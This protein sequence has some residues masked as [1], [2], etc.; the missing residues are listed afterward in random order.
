MLFSDP[1][2]QEETF[3]GG[4]RWLTI[5]GNQQLQTTFRRTTT[6]Q[7]HKKKYIVQLLHEKDL[8]LTDKN[9][10]ELLLGRH[11]Q[12]KPKQPT[13]DWFYNIDSSMKTTHDWN[14][15][16]PFRL[17]FGSPLDPL[18]QQSNDKP[19]IENNWLSFA[20]FHS[21]QCLATQHHI[22]WSTT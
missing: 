3:S 5:A 13:A 11:Q 10:R 19:S 8:S 21:I 2:R 7:H 12:H 4:T 17:L 14:I 6:P 18:T 22:W 20:F 9:N 16:V 15:L 1:L